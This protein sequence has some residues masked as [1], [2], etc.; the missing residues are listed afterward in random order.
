[1][2]MMVRSDSIRPNQAGFS[3]ISRE[4]VSEVV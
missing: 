2:G 4:I 1:M 3:D